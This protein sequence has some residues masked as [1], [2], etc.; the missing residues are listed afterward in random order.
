V[1]K[2]LAVGRIPLV[3]AVAH[4]DDIAKWPVRPLPRGG[5]RPLLSELRSRV[6]ERRS[7]SAFRDVAAVASQRHDF[8]GS[9]PV[10]E[11]RPVRNLM[12]S[13]F[14]PYDHPRPYVAWVGSVQQRKRPD[15]LPAIAEAV[16][17]LGLDL[18]V[19][20]QIREPRFRL[21][22]ESGPPNL[23]HLGLLP[24]AETIGLIAGARLLVVTAEEEGFANVLIQAWWYGT[25][26]VSLRHD[27]DALIATHD[28]GAS[29]GG[30][31]A[32]LLWRAVELIEEPGSAAGDRR[33]RIQG[34]AR[35]IFASDRTLDAL[36][37]LLH[38]VVARR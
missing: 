23:R 4:V 30:D 8:L 16:A 35:D 24:L 10:I 1:A 11:Q 37:G 6:G 2:Q 26:T 38:D 21:L 27:P 31:E 20:G 36:E 13:E 32:M 9:V 25:P 14:V 17:P 34:F 33:A 5:L 15:L 19:V 3:L 12:S 29:C 28:L 18:L 22:L 7:W